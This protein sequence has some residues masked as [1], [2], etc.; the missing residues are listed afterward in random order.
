[1]MNTSSEAIKTLEQASATTTAAVN[2]IDN[3]IAEHTYQDVASLA[4][5]AAAALLECANHLMNSQ[6]EAAFESLET[7]DDFL[8]E[9]YGIIDAD[10][11]DEE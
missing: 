4:A 10:L 9:I 11:E 3:L 7:A 1:M 8:N 2:I 5:K 6:D